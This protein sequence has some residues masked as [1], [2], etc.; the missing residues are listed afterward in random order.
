[1]VS[2]EVFVYIVRCNFSDPDREQA[3]NEWYSGPK[4][5]QVLAKPLFRTC[6]RF[7]LASGEGRAY[8]TLWTIQSPEA[9][10]TPE[11]RSDWGFSEWAPYVTD[12]TRDVFDGRFAPEAAFAV[13]LKGSLRVVSC[14]G[15][16]A[17]AASA[18]QAVIAKS[19][20]KMLWLPVIGLDRSCPMIGLQPLSELASPRES[21]HGWER[22]AQAGIYLPM[23]DVFAAEGSKGGKRF[24]QFRDRHDSSGT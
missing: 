3:W 11:Y 4:I 9:F 16:S 5:A 24:G 21:E 19:H 13:S 17:D 23:S 10:E 18:A 1:M 20:P 2:S 12:W 8:L 14:D 22:R 7:R 6:Q 15:M